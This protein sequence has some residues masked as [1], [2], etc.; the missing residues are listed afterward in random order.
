MRIY[1]KMPIIHSSTQNSLI[2]EVRVAASIG[3]IISGIEYPL[4][5]VF[6]SF[7][8]TGKVSIFRC[9]TLV[10]DSPYSWRETGTFLP[11]YIPVTGHALAVFN[12]TSHSVKT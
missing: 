10:S 12:V 6:S 5:D 8:E 1:I 4:A 7:Y 3:D 9:L 2:T 11:F